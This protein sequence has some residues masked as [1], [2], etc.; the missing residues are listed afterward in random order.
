MHVDD[1][2]RASGLPPRTL[3][4]ALTELEILG[5]IT[6]RDGNMIAAALGVDLSNSGPDPR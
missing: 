3:Q 1:L 6:R 5:R 4:A 2:I